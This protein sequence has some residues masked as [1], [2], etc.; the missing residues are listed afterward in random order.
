[1]AGIFDPGKAQFGLWQLGFRGLLET[2]F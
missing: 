1:L 2:E